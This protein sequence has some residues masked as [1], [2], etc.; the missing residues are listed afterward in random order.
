MVRYTHITAST[1]HIVMKYLVLLQ[2][3]WS[4]PLEQ[5][6]S[7][8]HVCLGTKPFPPSRPALSAVL[9][10][11]VSHRLDV[12]MSSPFR[13]DRVNATGIYG[14][15][16]TDRVQDCFKPLNKL[17]RPQAQYALGVL[18]YCCSCGQWA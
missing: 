2:K 7:V 16:R 18:E 1:Q 10:V 3:L 17:R 13:K 11:C 5:V 9:F 12:K 8:K 14:C 4:V 15:A 6:A